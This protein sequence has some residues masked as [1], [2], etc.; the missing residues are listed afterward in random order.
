M[1][2]HTTG[3]LLSY[4]RHESSLDTASPA[5]STLDADTGD[6]S[7]LRVPL[8]LDGALW[9]AVVERIAD[10]SIALIVDGEAV[11]TL[12]VEMDGAIHYQPAGDLMQRAPGHVTA[13]DVL[14]GQRVRLNFKLT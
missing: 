6:M 9:S 3:D 5:C 10:Q 7:R 2:T 14:T 8:E 13:A 12:G 1:H 4:L 11:S